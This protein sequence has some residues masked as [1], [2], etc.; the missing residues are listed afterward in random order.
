MN[1][2]KFI[3]K[4]LKFE[5]LISKA[6]YHYITYRVVWLDM[7]S[8]H[9]AFASTTVLAEAAKTNLF[10]QSTMPLEISVGDFIVYTKSPFEGINKHEMSNIGCP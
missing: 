10:Q 4:F 1:I 5:I 2:H 3:S 9:W 8:F 7:L 6:W